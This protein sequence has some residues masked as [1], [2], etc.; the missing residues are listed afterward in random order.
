V[1]IAKEFLLFLEP[2]VLVIWE[3]CS[4]TMLFVGTQVSRL[5]EDRRYVVDEKNESI[6]DY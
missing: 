4:C 3:E 5:E 2:H 1:P 6:L